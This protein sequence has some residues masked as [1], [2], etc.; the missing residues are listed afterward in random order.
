M[1]TRPAPLDI[2]RTRRA[3]R[4]T[5]VE[6]AA[7]VGVAPNTVA[8]WERGEMGMSWTTARLIAVLVGEEVRKVRKEKKR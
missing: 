1:A 2:R 6:F 8:R 5:Q 3:L 7:L 4:L